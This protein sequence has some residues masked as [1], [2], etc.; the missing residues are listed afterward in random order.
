M[1]SECPEEKYKATEDSPNRALGC[2]AEGR[3]EREGLCR[4]SF[5]FY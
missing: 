5:T 1:A 3:W 4:Q 2:V